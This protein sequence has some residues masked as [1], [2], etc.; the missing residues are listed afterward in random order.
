MRA[1][2]F[3]ALA[4]LVAGALISTAQP[5]RAPH[6]GTKN[7]Y[8]PDKARPKPSS[9]APRPGAHSRVYG[10]PIQSRILKSR[11]QK[12]PQLTSAPLPVT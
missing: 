11:P 2:V 9:L 5:V 7:D 3:C 8:Q 1:A 4:L 6:C 12:K 10:A